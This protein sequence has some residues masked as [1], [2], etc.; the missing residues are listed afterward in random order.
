[1]KRILLLVVAMMMFCPKGVLAEKVEY[2]Y[3]LEQVL[4]TVNNENVTLKCNTEKDLMKYEDEF[5]DFEWE[6]TDIPR[7]HLTNKTQNTIKL[8]WNDAVYQDDKGNTQ[9]VM[10]EGVRFIDKSKDIPESSILSL[11]NI[12]EIVLPVDHIIYF[13]GWTI[14]PLFSDKVKHKYIKNATDR[15]NKNIKIMLPFVIGSDLYEYTFIFKITNVIV[16]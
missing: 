11:G 7:F 9:K 10:H 16:S 4:V 1:M 14:Y 6:I 13:N 8:A 2:E 5:V 15:I 3:C 12:N